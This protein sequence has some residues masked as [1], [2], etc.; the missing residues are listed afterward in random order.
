MATSR[1]GLVMQKLHSIKVRLIAMALG[2]PI[3]LGISVIV[4]L[5]LN[6]RALLNNMA[7]TLRQEMQT[8]LTLINQGIYDMVNT[9]DQLLRIKL[10]GDLAVARDQLAAAGGAMLAEESV[11]WD[12]VNQYTQEKRSVRLPRMMV[13]ERWLGQN[14]S[15]AVSTPV[16]DATRVLV[17]GTCTIFQRMNA[18]GDMLRVATNV[19]TLDGNRAIGTYIPAM[20]ADGA[21]NQIV[22]SV[23]N[24]ERYIGRAFV[25][26]A[27]YVTAYEPITDTA[28]EVIGMLYVGILQESVED[29][30]QAILNTKVGETGYVFVLGGSGDLKHHTIVHGPLGPGVDLTETRDTDGNLFIQEMVALALETS[31]GASALMEYMW[32]DSGDPT[33]RMKQAALTYYEPWDWVIGASAYEEEFQEGLTLISATLRQA[34]LI[35]MGVTCAVLLFVGVIGFLLSS[36]I[37]G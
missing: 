26:N 21:P 9:Q 29:L 6:E 35:G 33:P 19:E 2:G 4:L 10:R 14:Y 18:A 31:N 7:Q 15:T 20:G 13:G 16:V 1:K 12:A 5:V 32:Q 23:L 25:V 27:W 34:M 28:G 11:S 8:N 36:K 22:S 37:A 17:G 3:I 30:H 24:G